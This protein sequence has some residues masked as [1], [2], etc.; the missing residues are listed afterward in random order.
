MKIRQFRPERRI[1]D[2]DY[3]SGPELSLSADD[4]KLG[5][6]IPDRR[7]SPRRPFHSFSIICQSC[8]RRSLIAPEIHLKLL[9]A[10]GRN[11]RLDDRFFF[12]PLMGIDEDAVADGVVEVTFLPFCGVVAW[13]GST[14]VI[15]REFSAS[16]GIAELH[17]LIELHNQTKATGQTW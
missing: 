7:F 4:L 15:S 10:R 9:P 2:G 6:T 13:V 17:G 16:S 8:T 3:P 12:A 5:R 1:S 14:L 11:D